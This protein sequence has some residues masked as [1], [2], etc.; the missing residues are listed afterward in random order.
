MYTGVLV[1]YSN[2]F[3]QVHIH[4]E[5]V[6]RLVRSGDGRVLF[7]NARTKHTYGHKDM[8]TLIQ[9]S[10]AFQNDWYQE[11]RDLRVVESHHGLYGILDLSTDRLLT[12]FAYSEIRHFTGPYFFLVS[13]KGKEA[14]VGLF[15][16]RLK[17]IVIPALYRAVCYE[18]SDFFRVVGLNGKF[19]IYDG[20]DTSHLPVVRV[21]MDLIVNERNQLLRAWEN[22]VQS[23]YLITKKQ[24]I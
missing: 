3:D 9:R 20:N 22:G 15:N 14:L 21:V 6:L 12:G 11:F 24:P 19:G 4:D 10:A 7:I 17:A 16:A 23:E 5:D 8:W 13:G 18:V 2:D 1:S